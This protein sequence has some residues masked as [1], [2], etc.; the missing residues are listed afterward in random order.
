MQTMKQ[1]LQTTMLIALSACVSRADIEDLK[2]GQQDMMGKLDKMEKM[3]P[4]RPTPPPMPPP[5]PD[6]TKVY[7]FN[8][9]EAATH[10]PDDAWV[11]IVEVSDFQCPFC[12]RA[13]ATMKEVEKAYGN[14][15]RIVFKHNPLPFHNRALPAAMAAEC[16]HDQ[17]KFWPVHDKMFENQQA[18]ADADLEN[19]AKA[20]GVDMKKFKACSSDQKF[21]KRI[22]DDQNQAKNFGARGTPAF[23]IN[24]HFLSGAQ[25]FAAFKTVIDEELSRAKGS[26][27]DKQH[28]Y[29]KAVEEKGDKAM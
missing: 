20:A 10:G 16:A 18:L 1:A 22:E 15:V 5:G 28:Y 24:G 19:Y 8:V 11:T 29:A 14:D 27:I 26:S 3:A 9:G 4:A 12:G 23:F 25:P 13:A 7:A 17:G 6:P 2:K 21:K